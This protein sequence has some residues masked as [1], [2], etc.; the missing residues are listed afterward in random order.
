MVLHDGN[1]C[2]PSRCT[3]NPWY[4]VRELTADTYL[5]GE[6]AERQWIKETS[7]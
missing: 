1:V 3:C 5:E 7:S 4:E 6:A 2:T